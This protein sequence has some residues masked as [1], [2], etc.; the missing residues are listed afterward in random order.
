MGQ[1]G[2]GRRM[3][4]KIVGSFIPY[5]GSISPQIEEWDN[6]HCR[7]AM[8]DSRKVRNHLNCVH[9]IALANLGELSTGLATISILPEGAK[10]ILKELKIEYIQKA[11]G[12]L[13]AIAESG[14]LNQELSSEN[15]THIVHSKIFDKSQAHVCSAQATWYI[16]L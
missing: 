15:V 10:I 16:R 1:H 13:Y 8:K 9:A 5:T 7:V 2:I 4:S 14:V 11:K 6:G 12:P 3:F